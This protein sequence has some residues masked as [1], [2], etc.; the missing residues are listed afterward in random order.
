MVVDFQKKPFETFGLLD[1]DLRVISFSL[2]LF[3]SGN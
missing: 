1:Y 3:V 2:S